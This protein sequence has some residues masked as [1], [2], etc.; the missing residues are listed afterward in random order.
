MSALSFFLKV[1][2]YDDLPPTNNPTRRGID[3]GINQ[4]NIPVENVQTQAFQI[5]PGAAVTVVD[6]TRATSVANDT[7]FNLALSPLDP[8]IYRVTWTGVGTA[9]VFRTSRNA[10]CTGIVLTLVANPNLTLTV[11]AGSG[12]PF[13]SVVAGDVAFVP[14]IM[15]GDVAGPFNS[16]NEGY[17]TV[18]SATSTVLTL[19]RDPGVVWSGASEVVTPAAPYDF[20]VFTSTGVQVGDT[21][22]I[23]AGFAAAT[24][25]SYD[26]TAVTPTWIEF[27]S[28]AP[29][30]PQSGIIPTAAGF[31]I[32]T[33]RKRFVGVIADQE[34]ILRYN[35]ASG[36]ENRVEPLLAGN[37][38][39]EGYD[40]KLG[41]AWKL[42]IVNRSSVRATVRVASAE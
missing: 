20:Q 32:Y 37:L 36:N 38:G 4:A 25:R 28:T 2:G 15:T 39:F 41:T 12:T 22:D 17:W 6:G 29:L 26:I 11:T 1:L 40:F 10:D 30:G 19:A 7:V 21:V 34:V 3:L 42:V 5:D 27:L 33:D 16:L 35:N 9:P 18:L 14:G 13:A 23:S 8:T 31:V 24:Q